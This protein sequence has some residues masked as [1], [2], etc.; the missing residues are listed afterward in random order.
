MTTHDEL[1]EFITAAA[2]DHGVPGTALGVRAAG[3][4]IVACWGVTSVEKPQP[5]DPDTLFV[6]G[7]V[8]KTFTATTLMRLAAQDRVEL[9][10][11]VRRYVPELVLADEDAAARITVLQL[12]NHTAGLDWRVRAETG[13]DDDALTAYV[14]AL[15]GCRLIAPPGT[16]ASY[17]QAGYNLAGRVI[18]KVTGLTYEQAVGSLLLEPLAMTHSTYA[19]D[20]ALDQR[21]ALGHNLRADG[22]LATAQQWKDSRANNPGAGLASSVTDQLRWARFHLGEDLGAGGERLLPAELLQRMQQPTVELTA[23]T[24]GDAIGIGWFIREVADTR[25]I[26]HGGSANGQFAELHLVPERGV[27]VVAV[28]NAGPDAGLAFNRAAITWALERFAGIVEH[29]AQALPFDPTR[30]HEVTGRYTNDLM[31]LIITTESGDLTIECRLKPD[32]RENSEVELPPDLPPAQ[33]G[34][35]P[36]DR[37]EFLI[38]TG[39]LAGQRGAFTRD[40][41]GA[42][43][44]A[45]LAGRVFTRSPT[46]G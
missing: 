8:S 45:D 36:G 41:D 28:S 11:P 40:P 38:S 14:D 32:V 35:L 7:S 15:S 39:G 9:D 16:R 26:S 30:A 23:S 34:F 17:S 6:L 37:D 42:I 21:V 10:A 1:A 25:V 4:N 13:D 19:P 2:P 22:T 31:I 24:L 33:L 27:A 29:T 46:D 44:A 12:L 5:V 43:T 3:Q 18:E 20:A